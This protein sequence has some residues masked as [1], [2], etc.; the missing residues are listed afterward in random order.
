[1]TNMVAHNMFPHW[2]PS[3]EEGTGQKEEQHPANPPN[4]PP[5]ATQA[6]IFRRRGRWIRARWQLSSRTRP[7][8]ARGR[9]RQC[10]R[11]QGPPESY[12][13]GCRGYVAAWGAPAD[14]LEHA[15]LWTCPVLVGY[16]ALE[17]QMAIHTQSPADF[18]DRVCRNA[19]TVHDTGSVQCN[20]LMYD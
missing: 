3:V 13:R 9:P 15:G 1:M 17:R 2:S 4:E 8:I 18:N 5:W 7:A 6:C 10:W 20:L 16:M 19:C 14:A 12:A 11:A